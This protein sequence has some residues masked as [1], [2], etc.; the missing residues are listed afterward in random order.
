SGALA[1]V[2]ISLFAVS[3]FDTDYILVKDGDL[4]RSIRALKEAGYQV[5]Y[6]V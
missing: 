4:I 2:G 1:Q 6:P 3:T 5:D